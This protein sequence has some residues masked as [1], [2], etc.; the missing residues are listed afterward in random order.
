MLHIRHWLFGNRCKIYVCW[1]RIDCSFINLIAGYFPNLSYFSDNV[2]LVFSYHS[3]HIF[4][5]K[6][7]SFYVLS[8]PYAI[9]LFSLFIMLTVISVQWY[10]NKL[11]WGSLFSQNKLLWGS[12]FLILKEFSQDFSVF[13]DR[14]YTI[15]VL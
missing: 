10:K 2:C 1:S 12:L 9:N 6:L 8:N 3:Y 5:E 7:Y 15:R 4:L 13:Q 14:C 11:L